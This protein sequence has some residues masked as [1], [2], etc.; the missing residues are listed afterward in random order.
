MLER[1]I[2]ESIPAPVCTKVQ[3]RLTVSRRFCDYPR[4]QK[5]K[6]C[7]LGRLDLRFRQGAAIDGRNRRSIRYL[8]RTP[9]DTTLAQSWHQ[10]A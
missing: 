1:H 9:R 4:G 3:R 6:K 7:V 10:A 5:S 2:A 8:G